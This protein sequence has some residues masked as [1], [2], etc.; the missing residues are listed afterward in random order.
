MQGQAQTRVETAV[1]NYLL[2][3]GVQ[4]VARSTVRGESTLAGLPGVHVEIQGSDGSDAQVESW[5][6]G[7]YDRASKAGAP[8]AVLIVKRKGHGLGSVGTWRAVTRH[9]YLAGEATSWTSVRDW[10][11]QLLAG[12]FDVQELDSAED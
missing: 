7:M 11:T 8:F 4:G 6:D 3:R 10:V 5:L 1:V 2:S 9:Q 12:C